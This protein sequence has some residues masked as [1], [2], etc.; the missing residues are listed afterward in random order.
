[1]SDRKSTNDVPAAAPQFVARHGWDGAQIVPLAA[2]ASFRRYFRVCRQGEVAVLM[3]APP[4]LEDSRPY[5]AVARHLHALDLRAP[6]IIA[7]DLDLGLMLLEDFGDDRLGPYLATHSEAETPLYQRALDSLIIAQQSTPPTRLAY[8]ALPQGGHV[9]LASYDDAVFIREVKLLTE[10]FL[11]AWGTTPDTQMLESFESAWRAAWHIVLAQTAVAPVIVLR[12]YH[13]DNL[14]IL[15]NSRQL[16]L[17]DFQDALAG[18]AAYDLVSLLQ[19]ARRDVSEALEAEM[20]GYYWHH[21]PARIKNIGE[22][23]FDAAYEVLGA[24]RN[25]KIIGIFTRLHRRDGKAHYP[26]LQPRVWAH[27][28]RNLQHPALAPVRAWFDQY[29]P[30]YMR[31][32]SPL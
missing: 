28:N 8:H 16:G 17:L 14:M 9:P 11:P 31:T 5:L 30:A 1:M 13:A 32:S 29:V 23:A 19:D 7:A 24:Q 12:D 27:L 22:A 6:Q 15:Q 2:D 4:Q 3:D 18:H 20:L 26:G 10:W 21:A 25:T